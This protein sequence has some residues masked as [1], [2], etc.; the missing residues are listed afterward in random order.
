MGFNPS[1]SFFRCSQARAPPSV[2]LRLPHHHC[3]QLSKTA[4]VRS[5]NTSRPRGFFSEALLMNGLLAASRFYQPLT[6]AIQ[7]SFPEIPLPN[8][9]TYRSAQVH[10][11]SSNR[12]GLL[13]STERARLWGRSPGPSQQDKQVPPFP[14]YSRSGLP[15]FEAK[16][17]CISI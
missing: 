1:S 9:P 17:I 4:V 6:P 12:V 8:L 14:Q 13:P 11:P 10:T 15:H 16:P 5:H 2:A 3:W 7:T